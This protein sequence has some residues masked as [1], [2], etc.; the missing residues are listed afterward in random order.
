MSAIMIGQEYD[1]RLKPL[2]E[3]KNNFKMVARLGELPHSAQVRLNALENKIRN[4]CLEYD[5]EAQKMG[6]Q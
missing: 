2:L 5:Q 3:E 6:I 1:R 4:L